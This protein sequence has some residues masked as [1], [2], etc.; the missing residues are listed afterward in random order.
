MAQVK[1]SADIT[2]SEFPLS[3]DWATRT[4][5]QE[6]FNDTRSQLRK[7]QILYAQDVLPTAQGLKSVSY[8]NI[9]GAPLV[10]N[11]KF[12]RVFTALD[13]AQ[14]KALI[15]ITADSKIYMITSS[16]YQWQ[17]VT[18]GGWAGFDFV[19][20]ATANGQSYLML[21]KFG[22]YKV[23][24]LGAALVSTVLTG[25]TVAN[26]YGCF[27]SVN[28]LC[29][30]D[31][32]IIY[33]SSTANPLDFTLS[34]ITGAGSST[35]Y[36]ESGVIVTV[37][38]LNNGFIVYTTLNMIIAS[39]S[40]NTQFPWIFRDANNSAGVG[41]IKNI[42]YSDNSGF[43]VALTF[44]GLQQVTV[45][46]ATTINPE[47]ADF[48][49][50]KVIEYFDPIAYKIVQTILSTAMVTAV[51]LISSRYIVVSYGATTL[52]DALVYDFVLQ[53]YGKLHVTHVQ[54]FEVDVSF[55]AS[56]Q[57]YNQAAE[58]GATYA[59][60]TP[61]TYISS[62]ASFNNSPDLGKVFGFLQTDGTIKLAVLDYTYTY[63]NADAA[64]VLL[65]KFQAVRAKLVNLEQVEVEV[66]SA[67]NTNFTVVDIPSINGKDLLPG[68]PLATILSGSYMRRYGCR[69]IGKN[70]ILAFLGNLHLT[71]VEIT[72]VLDASR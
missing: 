10:A 21:K 6:V 15:G 25:V 59:A 72:A 65:G 67:L 52:T 58:L 68:V 27:S 43:H 29:L 37:V 13:P 22:F 16:N 44:A 53:R 60:A 31:A 66:V 40:N 38:S 54:A 42:G 50:S 46:Q 9:V 39:F 47:V 49:A 56:A 63:S 64:V 36:D 17:D 5:E 8:L 61:Q 20:I 51:A 48:L 69:I 32:T 23:N 71:T 19:T 11:L 28:Y 1:F 45:Q 57:P 26:M 62:A 35:P 34:L 18:P 2:T 3:T 33:W 4:V 7:P 41:D 55:N 12:S 14:N 70:H 24:I 30:Y